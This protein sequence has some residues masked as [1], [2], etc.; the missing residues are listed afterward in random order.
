MTKSP[1]AKNSSA[2]LNL[3][4]TLFEPFN[5]TGC[6][7]KLLLSSEKRMACG[8][9]FGVDLG[10]CRTGLKGVPAK[11]LYNY[12]NIFRVNTFS[13]LFLSS[14]KYWQD[15]NLIQL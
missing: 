1:P 7:K 11:A 5:T 14:Y 3:A 2:I 13:H 10:L 12:I 15:A 9:D 6:V 4:V 8:T